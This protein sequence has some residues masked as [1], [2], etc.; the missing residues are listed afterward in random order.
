MATT[1]IDLGSEITI[2]NIQ[3]I[4]KQL[5]SQQQQASPVTLDASQLNKVDTAGA[6]MLFFFDRT[7]ADKNIELTW[8][9]L[10]SSLMQQLAHLGIRLVDV[11]A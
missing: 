10:Q 8:L 6:Q 4:Y 7:C 5:L 11:D 2:R 9:N 1:T 3:P